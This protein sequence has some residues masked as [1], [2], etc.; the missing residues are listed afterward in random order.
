MKL[1][2]SAGLSL[3]I[4][5]GFTFFIGESA[6]SAFDASV[7]KDVPYVP[8]R[9]ETVDEMLRM[10]RVD[11]DDVVYDLGCGDGRIVISAARNHGARGVGIDIDPERIAE[12]NENAEKAGVGDRVRFIEGDLFEADFSEATAVTLYLLPA[13]NV[14]LR[15]QLLAQ[16]RPGI[17]V[18]SHDFSM[19]EWE[20][21]DEKQIGLDR[22]FLWIIP[23]QVDGVWSW[24][25]PD[26]TKRRVN[27]KQEFQK[28]SGTSADGL[29]LV[30]G[31]LNG[32]EIEFALVGPSSDGVVE[33]YR[34]RVDG[35]KITGTVEKA[36][37]T[38]VRWSA[39]HE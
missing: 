9:Q 8:T 39:L 21:D 34:G 38:E 1:L 19:S 29:Q 10:A 24:T 13:V 17:P 20:P 27:L 31:R 28:F 14:K 5:G 15:P 22:L 30:N 18:V 26:G 12:A 33:R 3:L 6:Q 37:R 2:V 36:D 7:K 23:A 4:A 35:N 11:A 16:L 25:G 32:E